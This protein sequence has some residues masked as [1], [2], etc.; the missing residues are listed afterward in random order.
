[1]SVLIAAAILV[2]APAAPVAQVDAAYDEL[3]ANRNVEAIA[4][5]EATDASDG[6]PASLFNLGVAYARQGDT[7]RARD[8]FERAARLDQRVQLE[9]STGE[10]VDSRKLAL[11]AL[12]RIQRQ[13]DAGTRTAMR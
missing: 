2:T 3:V 8:A 11:R 5:I 7:E 10:W 9:T 6:H 13:S 1:M 4:Q 12:A